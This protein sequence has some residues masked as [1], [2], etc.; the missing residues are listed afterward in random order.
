MSVLLKTVLQKEI[1]V[2]ARLGK[3][4]GSSDQEERD[5]DEAEKLEGRP[6]TRGRHETHIALFTFRH[7]ASWVEFTVR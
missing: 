4:K 2:A 5:G 6:E 1:T 7:T 3:V